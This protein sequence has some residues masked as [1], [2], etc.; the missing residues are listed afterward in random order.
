MLLSIGNLGEIID[1][2]TWEVASC[3]V[4]PTTQRALA[5][6]EQTSWVSPERSLQILGGILQG[7]LRVRK[8]VTGRHHAR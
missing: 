3:H 1:N 8:E 4:F 7:C 5:I 6:V 2:I